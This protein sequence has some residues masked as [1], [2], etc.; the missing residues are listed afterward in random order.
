[1]ERFYFPAPNKKD[2]YKFKF[3]W[4]SLTV[5]TM[6]MLWCFKEKIRLVMF[7]DTICTQGV[8]LILG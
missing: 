8:I 2:T 3:V 7:A 1:M 4:N 6:V 5:L